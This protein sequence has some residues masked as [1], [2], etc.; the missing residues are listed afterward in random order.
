MRILL[1]EGQSTSAREAVTAL[2]LSGHEVEVADPSA[3]CF[4]RFS[5]FV[6]K[7]HRVPPI[8]SDPLGYLDAV[9]AILRTARFDVLVPIHEQGYAFAKAP[10]RLT[11]LTAVALPSFDAYDAVFRKYNFSR[12]L[13]ELGISQP[14]T[15]KV[16]SIDQ[17]RQ[18]PFPFLLKADIG[19]ASRGTW[20]VHN[21]RELEEALAR[22]RHV[23]GEL[24]VQEFMSGD[25]EHAQA[26]FAQGKMIAIHGYRQVARGVGGGEAIKES[27][28]RTNVQD[29]LA[30]I[31]HRLRWHGAFSVDYIY[32]GGTPYYI[33]GN[34]RLVEPMSALLAGVDLMGLL[35][36]VSAG[37]EVSGEL[38]TG[39]PGVRTRLAMQAILG[40]ARASGSRLSILQELVELAAGRGRYRNSTEELTPFRIDALSAVPL[41]MTTLIALVNPGLAASLPSRG[42]GAQLLTHQSADAIRDWPDQ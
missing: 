15:Q 9:V 28:A 22:S 34:P 24:L 8:A 41:V 42:W 35:L 30:R 5:R 17:L 33:D 25:V 16:A 20:V 37:K 18:R 29:D 7:V 2:G 40:T 14:P 3:L 23:A 27:V 38:V 31:G 11:P 1:S 13:A 10:R 6:R 21:G 12:L 26:V 32:S 36:D 4:C 19:T 39:R